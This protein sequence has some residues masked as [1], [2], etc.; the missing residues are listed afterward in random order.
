MCISAIC[1]TG[2]RLSLIST[3]LLTV[4]LPSPSA[5]V[6]ANTHA[7]D[8]M[9][10]EELVAK[11][12]ESLGTSEARAMVRS[13]AVIGTSTATFRI[14]GSTQA[15]GRVVL[16]SDGIKNLLAMAFDTNEY[17]AEKIGFD[18]KSVTANYQRPGQY[19]VLGN[20][21]LGNKIVSKEGLLGGSLSAAWPL[22]D[23]KAK[24]PNL[25]YAG[26]TKDDNRRLHKLEY[27]PRGGSD[28]RITLFFD[29]ETFRHVRTE[30]H[31]QV[32]GQLGNDP[33]QSYRQSQSRYAMVEEFSDFKQEHGLTLP[34]TYKLKLTISK[35]GG[36][37]D[38]DWVLNLS[39]FI[40]NGAI[41]TKEFNVAAG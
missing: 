22:L 25:R 14:K 34:H 37:F 4:I 36:S 29:G 5:V 10:P 33:E 23:L 24:S 32:T 26:S 40:F 16:A 19:S 41:D 28:L 11:H 38:A 39:Q 6:I 27:L 7:A 30:Y 18:G 20:F 2:V 8:K 17:P 21:I 35:Q 1:R 3:L 15:Q 13:R 9:E 31:M 12:L